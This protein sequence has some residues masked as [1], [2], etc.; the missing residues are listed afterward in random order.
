MKTIRIIPCLDCKFIGKKATVVKGIQFQSLK[1]IGNPVD[2]AKKYYNQGADEICF[3][4]ITASQESRKT[5]LKTIKQV[6]QEVFIPLTVG[7]GIKSVK[8][9]QKAFQA[10]ADKVSINTAALGN[11]ELI[12]EI[13]QQ[14]GQQACVIAMDVK[15]IGKEW[16]V[17]SYGGT[18]N[19]E[20]SAIEWAQTAEKLGAGE[21]LVTGIG[22]DG[23]KTGYDNELLKKINQKVKIPV[24]ASGGAGSLKDIKNGIIQGKA[25]AVLIASL[26]HFNQFT[27][28]EVKKYLTKKG[29]CVRL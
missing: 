23:M 22:N 1:Q 9:A 15:Q 29:I 25:D 19:T 14:F 13:S 16:L 12:Q 11:P 24:I 10:G 21:L 2:L 20:R 3:L 5:M 18:R 27:V 17:F 4:D 8:D 7:G 28:Q 26:F 6:S